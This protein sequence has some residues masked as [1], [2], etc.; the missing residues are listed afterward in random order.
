MSEENG[1]VKKAGWGCA[2]CGLGLLLCFIILIGGIGLG[3]YS[4]VNLFSGYE[5]S[6]LSNSP[7]DPEHLE[8]E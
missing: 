1:T 7:Y 8:E 4:L 3:L 5:P 2:G 6:A